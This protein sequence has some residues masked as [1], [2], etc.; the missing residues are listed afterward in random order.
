MYTTLHM[1]RTQYLKRA[2][3]DANKEAN[4]HTGNVVEVLVIT[5]HL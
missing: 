5:L 1:I 3:M 4:H 2:D